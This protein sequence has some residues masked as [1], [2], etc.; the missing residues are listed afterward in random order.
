[1]AARWL[2]L[3]KSL[4]EMTFFCT[5]EKMISA[6]LSQGA[7]TGVWIMIA[8]GWALRSRSMAAWPRWSEPLSMMTNTRGAL[9]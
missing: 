9:A 2:V 3:V 5:M 6:W 1:V 8:F 7:C 4:G